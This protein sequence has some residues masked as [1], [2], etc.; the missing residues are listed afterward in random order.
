LCRSEHLYSEIQL[1]LLAYTTALRQ[2]AATSSHYARRRT[3]TLISADDQRL[4][5]RQSRG[6]KHDK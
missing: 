6:Q 2:G 1:D 4:K 3:V 5:Y